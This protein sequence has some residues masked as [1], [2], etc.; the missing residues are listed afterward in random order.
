MLTYQM[1]VPTFLSFVP[2]FFLAVLLKLRCE[3]QTQVSLMSTL[4]R[5]LR[6]QGLNLLVLNHH[7]TDDKLPPEAELQLPRVSSLRQIEGPH[8]EVSHGSQVLLFFTLPKPNPNLF[9][10][11]PETKVLNFQLLFHQNTTGI[12]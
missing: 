6:K 2:I 1:Q 5:S 11:A 3:A 7:A 8:P 4:K 10:R 9:T 12:K